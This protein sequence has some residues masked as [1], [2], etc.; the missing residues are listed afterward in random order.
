MQAFVPGAPVAPERSPRP[1][2][3]PEDCFAA[4]G[5]GDDG[6]AARIRQEMAKRFPDVP[7]P[8]LDVTHHL[9]ESGSPFED[10]EVD[11]A[12]H[13][14]VLPWVEQSN[15]RVSACS[16]QTAAGCGG[17]RPRYILPLT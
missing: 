7:T 13:D 17:D 9:V 15:G 8:T 3:Q 11:Q 1:D 10:A 12:W 6:I 14:L 16:G 4:A 5:R 2:L